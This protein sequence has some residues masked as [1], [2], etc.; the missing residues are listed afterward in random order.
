M[1]YVGIDLHAY[2]VRVCVL[3]AQGH[4]VV[5]MSL[6]AGPYGL[7]AFFK[8]VP[9]PFK[10]AEEVYPANSYGLKAFAKRH[11]KNDRTD[12]HLIAKLLQGGDP[13]TVVIQRA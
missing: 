2:A 7:R 3:D 11:K 10:S 8:K 4:R 12:A 9:R 5:S 1:Y 13:P 6:P